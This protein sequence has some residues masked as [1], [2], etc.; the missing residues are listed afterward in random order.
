MNSSKRLDQLDAIQ[1][2]Y[3]RKA[4]AEADK[5]ECEAEIERIKLEI[6]RRK[7]RKEGGLS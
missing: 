7:I 1:A 5:A 4:D 3:L 6:W 2:A